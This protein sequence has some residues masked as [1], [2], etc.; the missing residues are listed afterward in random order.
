MRHT[1]MNALDDKS[2]MARLAHANPVVWYEGHDAAKAGK[3]AAEC[4][5]GPSDEP[6]MTVWLSGH[7]TS[8]DED[9]RAFKA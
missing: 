4:P 2:E 9:S 3:D 7:V 8:V 1:M 6:K 5:Y